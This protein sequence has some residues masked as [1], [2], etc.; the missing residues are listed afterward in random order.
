MSSVISITVDQ[1]VASYTDVMRKARVAINLEDFLPKADAG[2]RVLLSQVRGLL[3][4]VPG[5]ESRP[6][7]D[8]LAAE[9]KRVAG[10]SSIR[11]ACSIRRVVV[12]V[13]GFLDATTPEEEAAA[14]ADAGACGMQ[15]VRVGEVICGRRGLGSVIV[16]CPVAAATKLTKL[17]QVALGWAAARVEVL[18]APPQRCFRCRAQGHM[19]H[20]YPDLTDRAC[21]NCG[22]EDHAQC[23]NHPHCPKCASTKAKA[24]DH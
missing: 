8:W 11:I 14:M 12:R 1:K 13:S 19:Q 5:R 23:A 16:Q 21:F 2:F 15:D 18:K 7:A 9:M 3:L 24:S 4:E 17:G 20:R 10:G 22:G 6:A